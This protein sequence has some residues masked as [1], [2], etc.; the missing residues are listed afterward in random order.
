MN[1]IEEYNKKLNGLIVQFNKNAE[2]QK[3][4]EQ[5]IH[6]TEGVIEFLKQKESNE[7]REN[8]KKPE[9]VKKTTKK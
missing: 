1:K 7:I 3:H 9:K 6:R 2:I 4:V 5:Q 8:I